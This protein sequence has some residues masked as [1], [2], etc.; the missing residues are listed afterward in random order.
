MSLIS[1][2]NAIV[3]DV[4]I[5][6]TG[7]GAFFI[8]ASDRVRRPRPLPLPAASDLRVAGLQDILRMLKLRAVADAHTP[9]LS[10]L[11]F[12]SRSHTRSHTRHGSPSPRGAELVTLGGGAAHGGPPAV[13][14]S[15]TKSTH[16][17]LGGDEDVFRGAPKERRGSP[18]EGDVG[19]WKGEPEEPSDDESTDKRSGG[20]V[21]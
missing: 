19:F 7:L 8:F 4:V 5:S 20:A 6:T 18:D 15:V 17:D 14:V 12:A 10:A 9:K 11:S 21:V 2:F 1:G 3:P 13:A 16:V